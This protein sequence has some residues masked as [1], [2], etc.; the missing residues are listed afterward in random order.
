MDMKAIAFADPRFAVWWAAGTECISALSRR[1]RAN[2][3]SQS[4]YSA[5]MSRLAAARAQW[6]EFPPTAQLRDSAERLLQVHPLRTAD[7]LQLA[8]ALQAADGAP[9]SLPFVCLDNRLADAARAE[10]FAI[11]P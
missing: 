10:G 7:A 3:I 11:E 8:A 1:L 6:T 4:V 5:G 9:G 2:Q